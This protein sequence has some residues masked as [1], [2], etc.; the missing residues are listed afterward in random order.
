LNKYKYLLRIIVPVVSLAILLFTTNMPVGAYSTNGYHWEN[1]SVTYDLYQFPYSWR[2]AVVDAAET[3][4]APSDFS[5]SSG[6]ND[7][8]WSEENIPDTTVIAHTHR[9]AV[10]MHLTQATVQFNTN[11]TFAVGGNNLTAYNVESVALHEFGHWITL[12]ELTG[13]G[14]I[15]KVMYYAQIPLSPKTVLSQDEIDGVQYFY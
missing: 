12:E 10:G 6:V 11:K 15:Y 9:Y 3:W 4:S 13:I 5:L 1:T 2:Q 8:D 14:N 7:N